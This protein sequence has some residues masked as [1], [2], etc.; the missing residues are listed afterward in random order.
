[1]CDRKFR[2]KWFV[3]FVAGVFVFLFSATPV[4][5]NGPAPGPSIVV[6]FEGLPTDVAFVDLLVPIPTD[7]EY[8]QQY[9]EEHGEKYAIDASSPIVT[10]NTDG[11]YSYTFHYL[12][13]SSGMELDGPHY[14][15]PYY[16][17]QFETGSEDLEG[18]VDY[19]KIAL[20]DK[21][22]NIL[23][24]TE[25]VRI[26]STPTGYFDGV[27]RI[28]GNTFAITD[29]GQY[30]S[31]WMLIILPFRI[32]PRVA[33]S[34]LVEVLIA[35]FFKISPLRRVVLLNF[36]TQIILTV[37]MVTTSLSYWTSLIVGEAIVYLVEGVAMLLLYKAMSKK[38]IIAFVL[39]AN[40]V[41]L[42]LG[43]LLNQLGV[44]RY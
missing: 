33:F 28:D 40:T 3:A 29:D 26:A 22:G 4:S 14:D 36:A 42:S 39:I 35:Y 17:V 6:Q 10:Y 2:P 43:I 34:V 38:R 24:V 27:I 19:I 11:Y 12:G 31:P 32:L 44:F 21:D 41:T 13:A 8:F 25:T 20:L 5:A 18:K 16:N 30:T 9:N 23:H 1:M 15:G 37:F 7:S